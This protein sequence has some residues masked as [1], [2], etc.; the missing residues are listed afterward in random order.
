MFLTFVYT[1]G[2]Y[3]LWT[4]PLN[5]TIKHHF[6]YPYANISVWGRL[7][8]P[9]ISSEY[10]I[11]PLGFKTICRVPEKRPGVRFLGASDCTKWVKIFKSLGAWPTT[12]TATKNKNR[13]KRNDFKWTHSQTACN[14]KL[15]KEIEE[16][17]PLYRFR[18]F[19]WCFFTL[20][21]F[22]S[23]PCAKLQEPMQLESRWTRAITEHNSISAS[24]T[25]HNKKPWAVQLES[26]ME[27]EFSFNPSRWAPSR[28]L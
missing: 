26:L 13:T 16:S 4:L 22:T 19:F 6:P 18:C 3:K 23:F 14:D 2:H 27:V 21:I 25:L 15:T 17:N 28:S 1:A 11:P 7:R 5:S 20:V 12:T 9:K 8:S 24:T 10:L